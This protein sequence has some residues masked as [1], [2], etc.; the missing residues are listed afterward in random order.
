[1]FSNVV[2]G[3]A[4]RKIIIGD[5]SIYTS[6]EATG[7]RIGGSGAGSN[8]DITLTLGQ[9]NQPGFNMEGHVGGHYLISGN[10]TDEQWLAVRD[11]LKAYFK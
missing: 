7:Y 9:Y 4:Y 11:A 5:S 8:G 1:M 6:K 3:K 10:Y 2:D